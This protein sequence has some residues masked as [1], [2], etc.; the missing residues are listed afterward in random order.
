VVIFGGVA[1]PFLQIR[2]NVI[3]LIKGTRKKKMAEFLGVGDLHLTDSSGSGGLSKYLDEPDHMVIDEF[4][5]V[6]EYGRKRGISK[7]IQYGDVCQNPRMS[8]DA[9]LKLSKFLASNRDF[10]FYFILGNH[11]MYGETPDTGHSMEVLSLFYSNLYSKQNVK[12]YTRPKTVELDGVSVRFLP[13]PHQ[14]FDKQAL[15][16]FHKEVRGAKNDH[17]RPFDSEELTASKA[18]VCAGHLHTAHRVR[19]TYYSG[20]LYQT[21]FGESLPKF[22][23][24]IE[25]NSVDD[26]EIK[27]VKHDPKYKLHNIILQSRED[28]SLIPDS[29]TD[30]VKIVVQDGADV[31]K[32]DY[33]KYTNIVEEKNFKTKEDLAEVLTE[34]LAEGH[35]VQFKVS[36][37]FEAWIQSLDVEEQ[38]RSQIV[39]VRRR[40]LNTVKTR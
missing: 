5:K 4:S 28:L 18:V 31:S 25:F 39:E 9:M 1:L 36:D 11:D 17:G 22:F 26:F 16:V 2:L 15:N 19:N 29:A 12:I 20:T 7:V 10:E 14:S 27:Q 13:Y 40:V 38:M 30:L 3:F 35:E 21:N 8:Y 34:D 24:H 32:S 37:F 33:A 6:L 23:H